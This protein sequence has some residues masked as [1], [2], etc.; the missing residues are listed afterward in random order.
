MPSQLWPEEHGSDPE[1]DEWDPIM[2]TDYLLNL[3]P[4]TPGTELVLEIRRQVLNGDRVSLGLRRRL[5]SE[6]PP[7]P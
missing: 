6:R 7:R 1:W 2:L 4:Q 3:D 5:L